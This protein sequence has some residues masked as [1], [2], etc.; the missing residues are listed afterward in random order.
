MISKVRKPPE[1]KRWGMY[2]EQF[3][4]LQKG[5]IVKGRGG[6]LRIIQEVG[7]TWCRRAKNQHH[8]PKKTYFIKLL[9][10][11]PSWTKGEYTTYCIGDAALF[12]PIKVK[13]EKIWNLGHNSVTALRLKKYE[14][15]KKEKVRLLEEQIIKLQNESS[16]NN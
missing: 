8:D 14:Q 4:L 13:N 5:D 12:R 2:P 9:K 3:E 10:L 15:Y 6:D 16:R 1:K 11:R 7:P